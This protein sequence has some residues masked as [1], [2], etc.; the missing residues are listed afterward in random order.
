MKSAEAEVYPAVKMNNCVLALIR[1]DDKL[2]V[3]EGLKEGDECELTKGGYSDVCRG[4]EGSVYRPGARGLGAG[5]SRAPAGERGFAW[6]N[7]RT[8]GPHSPLGEGVG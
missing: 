6:E 5:R 7:P 4:A 8:E 3:L 2:V 1:S